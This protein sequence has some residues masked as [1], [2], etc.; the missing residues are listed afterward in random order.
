M[1]EER[2]AWQPTLQAVV[3]VLTDPEIVQTSVTGMLSGNINLSAYNVES[4][5]VIA[6]AIGVRC[7]AHHGRI[8]SR[9]VRMPGHVTSADIDKLCVAV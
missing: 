8:S 3:P 2:D 7:Y 6:N 4:I 5:L 9:W 1:V